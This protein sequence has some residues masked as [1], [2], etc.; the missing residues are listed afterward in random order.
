MSFAGF[1]KPMFGQ[2]GWYAVESN[3]NFEKNLMEELEVE[4]KRAASD[5][6]DRASVSFRLM[7]LSQWRAWRSRS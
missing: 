2:Y 4:S 5:D 6:L 1:G 7:A 3:F